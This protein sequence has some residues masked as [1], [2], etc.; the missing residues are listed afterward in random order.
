MQLNLLQFHPVH[1]TLAIS[2]VKAALLCKRSYCV[3]QE[4]NSILLTGPW[5]GGLKSAGSPFFAMLNLEILNTPLVIPVLCETTVVLGLTASRPPGLEHQEAAIKTKQR[6]W[7][8]P[9]AMV[10]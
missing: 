5:P 4:P 1:W 10:P 9:E 7:L 6:H 2:D 8:L 3:Y